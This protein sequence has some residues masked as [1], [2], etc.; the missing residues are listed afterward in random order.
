MTLDTT[1]TEAPVQADVLGRLLFGLAVLALALTPTQITVT[2]KHIEFTPAELVLIAA[3]VVWAIRWCKM[4]DTRSLPPL[5]NWLIILVAVLGLFSLLATTHAAAQLSTLHAQHHGG[6]KHAL[7][8]LFA[9]TDHQITGVKLAL[10]KIAQ[11]ALYLLVAVTVFR[12]V[13]TTPQRNRTAVIALLAGTTLAVLLG[14]I[15]WGILQR[16]YQP[17]PSARIVFA[18]SKARLADDQPQPH[19]PAQ[20]GY[21]DKQGVF[22]RA[23]RWKAFFCI[24]TPSAV[25]ST[26]GNWSKHGYHPS[27]HG[28]A[29]YLALVLPFALALLISERK[30]LGMILWMS[31]L[32]VGAAMSVM[33]GYLI[34]AIAIG[35]LATGISMGGKTV[36]RVCYALVG[37][38]IVVSVLTS[39]VF[40]SYTAQQAFLEP[41]RLKITHDE[42]LYYTPDND[43]VP[44]LKKFWA[45]QQAGLNVYRNYPLF[46]VGSGS[47][48]DAITIGYDTLGDIDKQRLEPDAQNGYIL[49]LVS[50]GMLGLAALLVLLGAYW[51][52]AHARVRWKRGDPW[53]AAQLGALAAVV[54]LLFA[55]NIWVRGTSIV[56]AALLA[57]IANYAT[58]TT[59]E[60]IHQPEEEPFTC[61]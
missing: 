8:R 14:V 33:A 37:Y 30:K 60:P 53:T 58:P 1:Q 57:M 38:Y 49:T 15:Q 25:S 43:G 40:H 34:P 24:E 32:F 35:L 17:V 11:L 51:R 39:V 28:Y 55:T 54:V 2:V 46:G 29:A 52:K 19:G 56:F 23:A 16:H 61:V 41:F 36:W 45:E 6:I 10:V 50:N 27:R 59:E 13:L 21:W 9:L 18:D 20:M 42:A 5:T 48:Q 4:R 44:L 12:A 22:H 26:F 31:L 3:A 7:A 47:Y